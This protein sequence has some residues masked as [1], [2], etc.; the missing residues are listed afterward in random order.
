MG[1][2]IPLAMPRLGLDP[3]PGSSVVIEAITDD[4]GVFNFL[5]LETVFLV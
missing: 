5:G 1:V 2:M 3:A 4:S